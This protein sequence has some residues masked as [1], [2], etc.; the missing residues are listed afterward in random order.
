M[1][2]EREGGTG[3]GWERNRHAD[4]TRRATLLGTLAIKPLVIPVT[5]RRL[6]AS[7]HS[8]IESSLVDTILHSAEV[9]KKSEMSSAWGEVSEDEAKITE[10]R[11]S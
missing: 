3:M 9:P 1:R 11:M 5:V 10:M 4:R 2:Q 7:H 8:Y 6:T